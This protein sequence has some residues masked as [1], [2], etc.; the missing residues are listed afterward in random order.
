VQVL[1]CILFAPSWSRN[2]KKSAATERYDALY[3]EIEKALVR[4]SDRHLPRTNFPMVF[5]PTG[6]NLIGHEIPGCLLV[7]LFELNT[8]RF[9]QIFNPPKEPK[10]AAKRKERKNNE[11][12]T[13]RTRDES[14][15]RWKQRMML[16]SLIPSRRR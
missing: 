6:V 9:R 4:R 5:F 8:S 12:G 11:E 16:Q 7:I 2:G 1:P 14:S 13:H 10:K 15:R 3:A